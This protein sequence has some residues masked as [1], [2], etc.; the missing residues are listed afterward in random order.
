MADVDMG[1]RAEAEARFMKACDRWIELRQPLMANSA[2]HKKRDA[3]EDEA[4]FQLAN[5]AIG[6]A[7]FM[8]NEKGEG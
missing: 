8:R 4:R 2:A 7:W 5:A 1:P 6:L 3:M